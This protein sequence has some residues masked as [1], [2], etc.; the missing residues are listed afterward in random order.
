MHTPDPEDPE[1][2]LRRD[3]DWRLVVGATA[4]LFVLILVTPFVLGFLT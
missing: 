2:V 4:L 1:R 3:D